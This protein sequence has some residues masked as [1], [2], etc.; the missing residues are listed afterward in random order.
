MK[1]SLHIDGRGSER[2]I[3]LIEVLIALVVLSIGIMA[4]GGIFPASTRTQL[5]TRSLGTA[6]YFAEQKAE[7]LQT[8]HWTDPNL[9]TGRHPAGTACDTLGTTGAWTRFYNVDAMAAPLDDLKRVRI[10][11]NWTSNGTRSV[12]DTIY[13]RKS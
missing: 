8:L 6:N 1:R 12:N 9:T 5:Q 3:T 11:V 2:G 10:T 7:E 4:I 13:V